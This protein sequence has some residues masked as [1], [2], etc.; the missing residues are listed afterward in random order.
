VARG[1]YFHYNSVGNLLS[2]L[3]SLSLSPQRTQPKAGKEKVFYGKGKRFP[4]FGPEA[5]ENYNNERKSMEKMSTCPRLESKRRKEKPWTGN[6]GSG[7]CDSMVKE[8]KS[9]VIQHSGTHFHN[10]KKEIINPEYESLTTIGRFPWA[11]SFFYI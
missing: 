9:Q 11:V 2:P 10:I 8:V 1:H 5:K 6:V 4:T 7:A 3:P